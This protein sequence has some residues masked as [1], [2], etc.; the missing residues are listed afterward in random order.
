MHTVFAD[1]YT[2]HPVYHRS[3]NNPYSV[4]V[5]PAMPQAVDDALSCVFPWL[6]SVQIPSRLFARIIIVLHSDFYLLKTR[7]ALENSIVNMMD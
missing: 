6:Y 1:E 2:D 3:L 5:Y 4:D 7:Q